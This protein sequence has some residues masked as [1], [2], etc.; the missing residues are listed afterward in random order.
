MNV[1]FHCWALRHPRFIKG[2]IDTGFIASEFKPEMLRPEGGNDVAL[3]GAAIAATERARSRNGGAPSASEPRSR[4]LEIGR[5]E[6][7]RG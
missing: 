2:D 4:W 1:A 7:L 5:R 3:I 6:A